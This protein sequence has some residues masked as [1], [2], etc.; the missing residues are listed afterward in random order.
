MPWKESV[1]PMKCC[2]SVPTCSP[3]SPPSR[4]Q[5][6]QL[7]RSALRAVMSLRQLRS[8]L[9]PILG[10]NRSEILM[11][12]EID[13]LALPLRPRKDPY[14]LERPMFIDR[15]C[16]ALL[17]AGVAAFIPA[18][19]PAGGSNSAAERR[20]WSADIQPV[21]SPAG[22]GS[23]APRLTTSDGSIILSW[24]EPEG[25]GTAL[26]FAEWN[27]SGWSATRTAATGDNWF[28]SSADLP[29]VLRMADGTLV[30]Q[31]LEATV[32]ERE[33]YDLSLSYSTD[34]GRTWAEPFTPHH[35]G[36]QSQHGFASLFEMPGEGLDWCGST[37]A[38]TSS[39][40]TIR[41]APR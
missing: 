2:R 40:R 11:F 16:A 17:V 34:E 28:V 23:S 30:A 8:Y 7:Q 24:F 36:T 5:R 41:T 6:G 13:S 27:E 20:Q 32:V 18:C 9:P 10:H 4:A 31:W 33:A 38:T 1:T 21:A 15:M 26:K 39:T 35:D 22:S 25:D 12:Q 14:S 29:S 19:S 3:R 37:A